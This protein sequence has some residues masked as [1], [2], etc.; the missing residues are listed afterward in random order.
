[1]VSSCIDPASLPPSDFVRRQELT[2]I[3]GDWVSL[4]HSSNQHGT[5]STIER[6]QWHFE[7]T[8][9]N[10]NHILGQRHA[11]VTV[12][13]GPTLERFECNH[14]NSYDLLSTY[15]LEGNVD[16]Q[17]PS[18]VI[19]VETDYQT[20]PSP[21]ERG[22]RHLTTYRLGRQGPLLR[23]DF[24]GGVEILWP[25]AHAVTQ[26]APPWRQ[27]DDDVLDGVWSDQTDSIDERGNVVHQTETWQFTLH[28]DHVAGTVRRD[29]TIRSSDQRM[30]SCAGGQ[31]YSYHDVIELS[32]RRVEPNVFHVQELSIGQ[33]DH[34]CITGGPRALDEATMEIA[35]EYAVLQWRG[36]RRQVLKRDR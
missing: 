13:A 15:T 3:A 32:G 30:M 25:S 31:Q 33:D 23:L 8:H 14:R 24:P 6:S 21:C 12:T 29:A 22:L 16:D 28:D 35:G 18:T 9:D 19:V 36:K 10:P 20:A 2:S 5:E 4:A 34:P 1:M 27:S 11:S 17:A 7:F 26:S